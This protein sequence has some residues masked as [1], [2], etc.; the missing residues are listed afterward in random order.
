[1]SANDPGLY[2]GRSQESTV[3]PNL[4]EKGSHHLSS[5]HATAN[6]SHFEAAIQMVTNPFASMSDLLKL[7]GDGFI[8]KAANLSCPEKR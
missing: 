4:T 8:H 5:T 7:V 2:G 3:I 6:G 1:M